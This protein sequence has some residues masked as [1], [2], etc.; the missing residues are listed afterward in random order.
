MFNELMKE[1]KA[2]IDDIDGLNKAMD[3][4]EECFIWFFAEWCGYCQS[5]MDDWEE[6]YIA[7]NEKY[8][9]FKISDKRK[10]EVNNN[11][12]RD[13]TGFPQFL[14]TRGNNV[15][16][17]YNGD[18]TFHGLEQFLKTNFKPKGHQLD[19]HRKPCPVDNVHKLNQVMNKGKDS[20]IWFF[21]PWCGHCKNMEK[22][23]ED[24]YEQNKDKYN[25]FKISDNKKDSV[26]NNIGT[27]VQSFPQLIAS[28]GNNVIGKHDGERTN[29]AIQDF[30]NTKLKP[31]T[32]RLNTKPNINKSL[33]NILNT[34]VKIKK[35]NQSKRRTPNTARRRTPN[36]ARRRTPNTTR[37]RTPNTTKRKIPNTAR[38][39]TPNTAK[40]SSKRKKMMCNGNRCVYVSSKK[41]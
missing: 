5:V 16:S 10:D 7:H 14:Y 40:R 1:K 37:R 30:I 22:T 15:K 9:L 33:K 24:L 41:T 18:R 3:N 2:P 31:N 25:M 39:R 26:N 29:I 13:V 34:I 38:R 28:R 17:K 36:T 6:L 23:W 27:Q 35:A 19:I 12:G 4:G 32:S 11:I 21:A 20:L 8:N